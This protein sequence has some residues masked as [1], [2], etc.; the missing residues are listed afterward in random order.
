ML[1]EM[2]KHPDGKALYDKTYHDGKAKKSL[3]P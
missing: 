3:N 1:A 2:R